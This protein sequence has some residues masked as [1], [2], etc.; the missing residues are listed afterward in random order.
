MRKQSENSL[1]LIHLGRKLSDFYCYAS[2]RNCEDTRDSDA[3]AMEAK[4]Y[5][6]LYSLRNRN[7]L[8]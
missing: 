2:L 3:Q 5:Q 4:A 7:Q 1:I 6:G 8:C